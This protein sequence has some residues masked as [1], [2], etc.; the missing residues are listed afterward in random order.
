MTKQWPHGYPYAPG[1]DRKQRQWLH[2]GEVTEEAFQDLV[3]A[4]GEDNVAL[5]IGCAGGNAERPTGI[6]ALIRATP[7]NVARAWYLLDEEELL[8]VGLS[9]EEG[10]E[11]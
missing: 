6:V 3:E 8:E 2:A 10:E 1:H 9:P 4:F 7:E 5:C 11:G